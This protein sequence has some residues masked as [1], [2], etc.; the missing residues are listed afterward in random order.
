MTMGNRIQRLCIASGAQSGASRAEMQRGCRAPLPLPDLRP[1]LSHLERRHLGREAAAVLL[2]P[3]EPPGAVVARLPGHARE[4]REAVVA[5]VV[6]ELAR[7]VALQ[8]PD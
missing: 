6:A 1:E 4:L 3:L 2:P 8:D 5:D 7:P